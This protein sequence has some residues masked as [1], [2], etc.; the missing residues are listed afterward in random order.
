VTASA[1]PDQFPDP[2]EDLSDDEF[3]REILDAIEQSTIKISLRVPKRLLER[4]KRV[5]TERGVPYQALMKA[6]LDRGIY[7]LEQTQKR[8]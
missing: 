2:Y 3:E 6:L 8:L 7:R 1:K 5:A 4:T